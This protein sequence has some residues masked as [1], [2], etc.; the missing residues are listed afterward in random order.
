MAFFP[1]YTPPP[2][3]EIWPA[4]PA[5]TEG[6]RAIPGAVSQT[7]TAN[8]VAISPPP[9]EGLTLSLPP[10]TTLQLANGTTT[11]LMGAAHE[12]E[13]QTKQNFLILD[14]NLRALGFEQS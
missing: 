9:P 6:P 11:A 14:M 5:P 13:V 2:R 3:K 4:Q 10:W 8:A 1:N 12:S 7:K